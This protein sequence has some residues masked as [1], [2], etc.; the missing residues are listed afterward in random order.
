[1]GRVGV[2]IPARNEEKYLGRTLSRLLVQTRKPDMAVV[3]D[4]GSKDATAR[5]AQSFGLHVV[6]LED[7]G[8][9]AVSRPELARVLNSGLSFLEEAGRFDYVMILGAEQLL[10]SDYLEKIIKRVESDERIVIASGV[11][12]GEFS[13]A[14]RGSGRIYKLDF[15]R[16]IGFF[17]LNYGWESYP[18]VKALVA[19][20]KVETFRDLAMCGQR[21]T[22]VSARKL[23][24]GGKGYKALG[25]DPIYVLWECF[26][27]FL[28]SPRGALNLLRGYLSRD[29]KSYSDV[30]LG[31]WQRRNL[32]RRLYAKVG[33]LLALGGVTR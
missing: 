7:R 25:C 4:D 20:Y 11:V 33:K 8:F 23:Y 12:A 32:V 3:V 2:C 24:Y 5:I 10:P 29:V 9:N 14:P 1:M 27:K 6:R 31:A 26:L 22:K 17:P 15:L 21:P 16:D 13:R 18:V 19:G 28:N 30:N